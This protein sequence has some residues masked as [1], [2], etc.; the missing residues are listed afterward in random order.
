MSP[1]TI[2]EP[3]PPRTL[4]IAGWLPPGQ[5]EPWLELLAAAGVEAVQVREKSLG[6]RALFELARRV[7]QRLAGRCRVL[8]NGRAD[9]ALA[10][11]ADG[12]HLPADGLPAAPLRRRC[13]PAFLIGRSTHHPREVAAALAEGCDYAVFGPVAPTPS[14]PPGEGRPPIPGYAGLREAARRGLPL[15]ALGGVETPEDVARAAAAGAAGVA[16][17]RAFGDPASAAAIV[18]AARA[19]WPGETP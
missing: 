4:A 2:S 1:P 5:L 11:G 6:D 12:V 8:V 19:A 15:L 16:A 18:A 9:L 13:G 3:R 14:K 7:V 10:A 17:I